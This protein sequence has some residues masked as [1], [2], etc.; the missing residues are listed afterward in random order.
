VHDKKDKQ[1]TII[2]FENDQLHHTEQPTVK[3]EGYYCLFTDQKVIV[4]GLEYPFESMLKSSGKQNFAEFMDY[5][6]KFQL[7][8]KL[9]SFKLV[10]MFGE[11][12]YEPQSSGHL[13]DWLHCKYVIT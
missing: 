12:K 3:N 4:H 1:F 11:A 10:F 9:P 2:S 5:A 7:C 8:F 6:Y 13:L